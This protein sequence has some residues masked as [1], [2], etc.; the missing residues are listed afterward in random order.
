[1]PSRLVIHKVAM[2]TELLSE[3]EIL[4]PNLGNEAALSAKLRYCKY[5]SINFSTNEAKKTGNL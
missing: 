1:M 4:W 2:S 5:N 3:T